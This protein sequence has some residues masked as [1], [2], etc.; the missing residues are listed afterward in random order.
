M[1]ELSAVSEWLKSIRV[2]GSSSDTRTSDMTNSSAEHSS[3]EPK[4]FQTKEMSSVECSL[5][6]SMAD[7]LVEV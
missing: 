2:V 5:E 3:V 6:H 1:S 7:S 4:S